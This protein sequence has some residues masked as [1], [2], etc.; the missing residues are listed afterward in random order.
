M[1]VRRRG[2]DRKLKKLQKKL[3]EPRTFGLS[4]QK[5]VLF[6]TTLSRLPSTRRSRGGFMEVVGT[7][8]DSSKISLSLLN[9]FFGNFF[10]SYWILLSC[11]T[12]LRFGL[13]A[14]LFDYNKSGRK[15]A[16]KTWV[17]WKKNKMLTLKTPTNATKRTQIE[18]KSDKK[19]PLYL[20]KKGI[21]IVWSFFYTFRTW[22]TP[23]QD[24]LWYFSGRSY[25][26]TPLLSH[27]PFNFNMYTKSFEGSVGIA[28]EIKSSCSCL[29]R[30]LL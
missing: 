10:L 9:C 24:I 26:P 1:W 13:M 11:F 19:K 8:R 20:S 27:I 5:L 18:S 15:K 3:A 14:K 29:L 30:R 7:V 4:E 16:R 25:L 22:G 28:L 6:V 23:K 2:L 21:K 17:N 12:V